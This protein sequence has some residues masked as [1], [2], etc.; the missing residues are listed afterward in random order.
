MTTTRFMMVAAMMSAAAA[1]PLAIA[2]DPAAAFRELCAKKAA[3]GDSM[4]VAGADGWLFLRAELRHVGVGPF[5]GPAAAA[6]SRATSPDKADPLPAIVDFVEQMKARGIEVL[7]MP[8]PC[9]AVVYPEKLVGPADGRVDQVYRDFFAALAAKGVQVV[10]LGDGFAAEKAADELYCKTDTH[11]SPR[12]CERA[13]RLLA[14]RIGKV[15]VAKPEA[16]KTRTENRT[17]VGDLT[18]GKGSEELPARVVE[19]AD[20]NPAGNSPLEDKASPVVVMG[21]SHCLVFHAGGDLHGT[22]AG[23]ADQLAAELGRAVDV[24]GVRGSGATPARVNLL[25]RAKADPAYLANKKWI[26]WCFAA[27]EFTES[28]GWSAVPFVGVGVGV[29]APAR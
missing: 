4:A 24:I 27:R 29:G 22:G 15:P 23:L 7:V 17:V 25:R 1:A 18:E 5:W 12:A 9:K 19:A 13:A 11:W 20:T 2:E 28:A 21:D 6:V 14:T 26:V 3:D 10:D 8:V 16:F